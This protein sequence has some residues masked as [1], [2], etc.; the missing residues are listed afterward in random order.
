MSNLNTNLNLDWIWIL[1]KKNSEK[2]KA[3]SYSWAESN[4]PNHLSTHL[5]GPLSS[6]ARPSFFPL[7]P[8]LFALTC[9]TRRSVTCCRTRSPFSGAA[10]SAPSPLRHSQ[11]TGAHLELLQPIPPNSALTSEPTW[12]PRYKVRVVTSPLTIASPPSTTKTGHP[13]RVT[14]MDPLRCSLRPTNVPPS[15]GGNR[16]LPGHV[17]Y[18]HDIDW[19]EGP[20]G[21]YELLTG[22]TPSPWSASYRDRLCTCRFCPKGTPLTCPHSPPLRVARLGLE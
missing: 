10:R 6:I 4:Q 19:P 22:L 13:I 9:W 5:L 16:G 17:E 15:M 21:H 12:T 1:E 18:R 7:L 20:L 14:A 2:N 3:N 11:Q 8:R